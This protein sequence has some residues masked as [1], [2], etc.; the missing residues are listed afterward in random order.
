VIFLEDRPV[1]QLINKLLKPLLVALSVSTYGVMAFAV[2]GMGSS[3]TNLQNNLFQ[4]LL[5]TSNTPGISFPG[6]PRTWVQKDLRSFQDTNTAARVGGSLPI[7]LVDLSFVAKFSIAYTYSKKISFVAA[8]MV[9]ARLV[10]DIGPNKVTMTPASGAALSAIRRLDKESQRNYFVVDKAH[11]MIGFCAYEL[12]LNITKSNEFKKNIGSSIG[13]AESTDTEGEQRIETQTLYS[14]IFQIDSTIPET[15]YLTVKCE[16]HFQKMVRAY[17]EYEFSKIMIEF[18]QVYGSECREDNECVD[19]LNARGT[20]LFPSPLKA[21]GTVARC[22][23]KTDATRSCYA[24][25]TEGMACTLYKKKDGTLTEKPQG[26]Y[27]E[28][29]SSGGYPCDSGLKCNL[30]SNILGAKFAYCRKK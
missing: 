15:D 18:N 21:K 14:Q 10:S 30:E 29:T 6:Y 23:Q 24:R 13:G 17:A 12:Q 28:A 26:I 2:T 7:P 25:S 20:A 16:D 22:L 1:V 5:A 19:Q 11:P 8:G 27:T 4:E 3:N 9:D